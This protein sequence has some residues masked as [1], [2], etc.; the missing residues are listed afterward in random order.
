MCPTPH[1]F[2]YITPAIRPKLIHVTVFG[3]ECSFRQCIPFG[4]AKFM[5]VF[6]FLMTVHKKLCNF[7]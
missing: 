2:C 3:K 6:L 5:L 1:I 7:C 4:K